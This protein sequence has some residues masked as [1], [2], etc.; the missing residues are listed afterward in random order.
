MEELR[1]IQGLDSISAWP[2]AIGWWIII[3][4]IAAGLIVAAIYAYKRY[5]YK[6]SWQFSSFQALQNIETQLQ[7]GSADNKSMLHQLAVEMRRI[8]MQK[9]ARE[10][11]AG[12]V[13]KQWLTWLQQ[14]DPHKFAWE[15]NGQVLIQFQ[16]MPEINHLEPSKLQNLINAAKQWVRK[17]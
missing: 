1:D 3:S 13:G 12:L 4:M 17:C 11:C 8:A 15:S 2:L 9:F 6:R 10:T 5:K 16:Y 7:E 14:H